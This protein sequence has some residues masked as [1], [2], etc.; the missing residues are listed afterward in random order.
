MVFIFCGAYD[1][2]DELVHMPIPGACCQR[3][4]FRRARVLQALLTSIRHTA[5]V[6]VSLKVGLNLSKGPTVSEPFCAKILRIK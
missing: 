6:A 3:A 2:P 4:S 5:P 1:L